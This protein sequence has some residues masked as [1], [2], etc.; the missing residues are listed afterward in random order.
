MNGYQMTWKLTGKTYC[1]H[2]AT[3]PEAKVALIQMTTTESQTTTK[4]I[5]EV[6]PVDYTSLWVGGGFFIV[7]AALLIILTSKAR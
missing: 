5:Q 7:F 3:V 1:I 4:E 6:K 2:N